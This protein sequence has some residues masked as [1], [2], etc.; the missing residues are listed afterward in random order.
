MCRARR[1]GPRKDRARRLAG[2]V[3]RV[4]A[5][6]DHDHCLHDDHE[7]D[8]RDEPRQRRRVPQR[9][10]DEQEDQQPEPGRVD[11]RDQQRG[12]SRDAAAEDPQS[13]RQAHD[14]QHEATRLTELD[15]RVRDEHRDRARAK[16]MTPSS[17]TR[18]PGRGPGSRT[19]PPRRG[20]GE[21][22]GGK[23]TSATAQA[24]DGC[25]DQPAAAPQSSSM[26]T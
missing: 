8:R 6:V 17:G 9:P 7:A 15:V 23:T 26:G 21:G 16:L 2:D 22:R 12:N 11:Q 1:W 5:Q 18:A 19:P 25:G 3:E 13:V 14:G 20:R 4:V 24:S 10:E